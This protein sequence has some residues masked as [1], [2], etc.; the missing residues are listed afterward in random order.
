MLH[1]DII[2]SRF[3]FTFFNYFSPFLN[4][5]VGAWSLRDA[6]RA[7]A[8]LTAPPFSLITWFMLH[9]IA[10]RTKYHADTE[11][12]ASTEYHAG[13]EFHAACHRKTHKIPCWQKYHASC[14]PQWHTDTHRLNDSLTHSQHSIW[15]QITHL[16]AMQCTL[17]DNC[18]RQR[19]SGTGPQRLTNTATQRLTHFIT[20]SLTHSLTTLH[21]TSNYTPSCNAMCS[22]R[23]LS[24]I[25]T[26]WHW[27]TETH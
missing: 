4:A 16:T 3:F 21:L 13:T 17:A 18:H 24:L 26:Q 23:Q 8:A 6:D 11:Y 14:H 2:F 25:E 27:P 15:R 7:S 5:G 10:K 1:K 19:L 22:C 12:Y 9:D 20:H